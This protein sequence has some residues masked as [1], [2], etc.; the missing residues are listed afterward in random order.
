MSQVKVFVTDEQTDGLSP[1]F[2]KM[3]RRRTE[4]TLVTLTTGNEQNGDII[5]AKFCQVRVIYKCQCDNI[6]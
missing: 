5:L 3:P 1:A 6:A 2:A 4:I